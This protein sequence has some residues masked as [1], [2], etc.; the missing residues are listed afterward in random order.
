MAKKIYKLNMRQNQA[1]FVLQGKSG[2]QVR[3]NFTQGNAAV[4][5]PAKLTLHDEYCQQ[6]LESSELFKRGV[7]Q[8]EKVEEDEKSAAKVVVEKTPKMEVVESVKTV[9]EAVEY[10]A[11]EWGEVV[12]TARQA[13]EAAEKH[14]VAFPNLRVKNASNN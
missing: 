7:V 8:L 11:N 9:A 4:S 2:N 13:K 6:L 10:V 14:G 12:K 1:S 5:Y 3:Y